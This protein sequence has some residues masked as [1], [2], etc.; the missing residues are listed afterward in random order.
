MAT[1]TAPRNLLLGAMLF[2]LSACAS[3]TPIGD[4]LSDPGR[5]DGRTVRI[6]GT[7]TEAAGALGVGGYL[8][9]DGTGTLTVVSQSGGAPRTGAEVGVKGRFEALFTLG[10]RAL[11]VLR[12]EDRFEP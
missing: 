4:L 3:V 10:D 5:Y 12:E 1:V 2:S 11:A 6:E 7:V 9:D 8:V